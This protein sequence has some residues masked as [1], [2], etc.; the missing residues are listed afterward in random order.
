MNNTHSFLLASR[1]LDAIHF[2]GAVTTTSAYL[3]GPGGQAGDGFPV[4][5]RGF[6]TGLRVWDGANL[7]SDSD[8]IAFNADDRISLYCQV[9][10]GTFT[11]KVRVNGSSTALEVAGVPFN[12]TLFATLEFLLVRE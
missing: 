11:V 9:V 8:E 4:T 6:L 3:N 12:T 7:H 5:R 2:S 1:P 10:S